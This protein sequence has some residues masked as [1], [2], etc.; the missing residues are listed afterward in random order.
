MPSAAAA[1]SGGGLARSGVAIA[2]GAGL[3]NAAGFSG[4]TLSADALGRPRFA[5]GSGKGATGGATGA[6]TVAGFAARSGAAAGGF[7]IIAAAGMTEG[8][9]V[10]TT[11]GDFSA[12]AGAS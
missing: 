1:V 11:G 7:A 10:G 12:G 6:E 4:G 9:A 3:G 5:G 8:V 2:A